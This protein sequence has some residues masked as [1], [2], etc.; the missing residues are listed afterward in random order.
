MLQARLLLLRAPCHHAELEKKAVVWAVLGVQNWNIMSHENMDALE[1]TRLLSNAWPTRLTAQMRF[2][3]IS[4][5][6]AV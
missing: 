4:P 1:P 2:C 3:A 6:Q 5:C